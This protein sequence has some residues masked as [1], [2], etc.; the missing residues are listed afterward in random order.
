MLTNLTDKTTPNSELEQLTAEQ[1]N[2]LNILIKSGV[3]VSEYMIPPLTDLLGKYIALKAAYKQAQDTIAELEEMLEDSTQEI[4][5][6]EP[7]RKVKRVDDQP[8]I[9]I[10]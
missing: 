9:Y 7:Y 6:L 4:A 8:P 5:A 1:L 2:N 10:Q 3:M